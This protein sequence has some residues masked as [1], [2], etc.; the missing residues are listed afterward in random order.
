M[1]A[2]RE[3]NH[4]Q[5]PFLLTYDHAQLTATTAVKLFKVPAGRKLRIDA[6]D[7]I[8][9]TGLAADASNYFALSLAGNTDIASWSTQTGAEGAIAADTFISLVMSATDADC[10][11]SAGDGLEVSF[12]ETGTA[13]LPAGR[14][15]VRGRWVQ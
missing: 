2:K 13:T 6:V 12:S 3:N 5:E 11:L 4:L 10:V 15:V 14:L 8:N 7:Y 1:G 9:P